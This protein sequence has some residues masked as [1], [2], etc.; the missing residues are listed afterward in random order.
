MNP[1]TL[2]AT[3]HELTV[4]ILVLNHLAFLVPVSLFTFLGL[5]ALW[6]QRKGN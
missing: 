5:N 6:N 2:T 4:T 3:I 1:H